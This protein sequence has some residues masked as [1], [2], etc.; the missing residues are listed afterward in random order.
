MSKR[1]ARRLAHVPA[2]YWDREHQITIIPALPDEEE[3][4]C[5]HPGPSQWGWFARDDTAPGGRVFCVTCCAC[6]A[7]LQGGEG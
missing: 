3:G 1:K 7:V 2:P 5:P 6:G 4:E